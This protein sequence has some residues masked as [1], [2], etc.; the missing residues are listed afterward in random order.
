MKNIAKFWHSGFAA[1][2]TTI[3]ISIFVISCCCVS[4]I[5]A[6]PTPG[7]SVSSIS[8]QL[9]TTKTEIS[10]VVTSTASS[11]T[12]PES[13]ARPVF[14]P[15][16]SPLPSETTTL[17]PTSTKSVTNQP[18][19]VHFIDVGQGDATLIQTT[20][21]FSILIDGGEA[22]GDVVEYLKNAGIQSIDLMI[23]T[24]PHS[25]HI[26][27]LVEVLRSFPV[28]KVATN[29]QSHT[30]STYED[31]LDAIADARAEYVEVRRGDVLQVGNLKLF[32]LS[33]AAN[34]DPDM[35]ENSVV[36]QF[37]Y[38]STSY[39][40]MGDAGANTEAAL[41]ASGSKLKANI[42]K[43]GHHGSKS[44][45]TIPFLQAVSPDIAIYFAGENNSYGHPALQTILSLHDVDATIYGTN[46]NGSIIVQ[47][48]WSAYEVQ[49]QRL[50]F[51]GERA[52]AP[53]SAP[54]QSVS[55]GLEI[56]SVTSPVSK[57][58]YATL[59]AQ[60]SP[61]ASCTITVY[62]KSGPSSAAGLIPQNADASGNVSWTWKVGT[63]TTPGTWRIV[64]TCGG[65]TKET[66]FTV[67]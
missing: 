61:N 13:T 1:K 67:Q 52:T 45:S 44:G 21:G 19:K 57:G 14:S 33:P 64:V 2:I 50:E 42:L 22:N 32:V 31:F 24:H 6:A 40:L 9:A 20:D 63:R 48:G 49:T 15:T 5:I 51:A 12:A 54:T 26:G 53:A 62:Y 11:T 56:K 8:T 55:T 43:V 17:A 46:V 38:G 65:F 60:T 36:L 28:T 27:G 66:S 39:L 25:D 59:I 30:T 47:N 18:F 58:G 10:P 34:D 3:I 16:V 37:A 29:G 4:L 35:N 23:A 41:L 7:S